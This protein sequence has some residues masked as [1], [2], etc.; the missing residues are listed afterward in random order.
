[1]GHATDSR[2]MRHNPIEVDIADLGLD[3]SFPGFFR[4][5]SGWNN[6]LTLRQ[7]GSLVQ[8]NL[9]SDGV[10]VDGYTIKGLEGIDGKLKQL[11]VGWQHSLA[12]IV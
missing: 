11:A 8:M 5:C 1:M 2:E 7:D 4:V 12:L 3:D 10:K 9:N 6:F